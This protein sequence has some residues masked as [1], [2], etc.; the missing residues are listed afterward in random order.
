MKLAAAEFEAL[1]YRIGQLRCVDLP[2]SVAKTLDAAPRIPVRVRVG[3]TE[4]QTN[5][6]RTHEGGYRLYLAASLR[7]R[8]PVDSGDHVHVSLR[9]DPQGAEPVLPTDLIVAIRR[10]PGC[11]AALKSR[12]P[13][14]RRQLVRWVEEPKSATARAH[15]IERALKMIQRGPPRRS[16][17]GRR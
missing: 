1:I 14:D 12:S 5:L 8:P 2:V 11:M 16:T 17:R 3:Q 15:R 9:P 4:G 13:A 7:R 6:V 10:V